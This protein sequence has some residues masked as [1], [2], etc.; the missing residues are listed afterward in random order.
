MDMNQNWSTGNISLC[1]EHHSNS[2]QKL[3]YSQVVKCVIYIVISVIILFALVGNLLIIIAI[4]H[5][6]QLHTPTNYFTLSLAVTDLLVG[7][8][9]MPPSMIRTVETC[10]YLGT[11]FC[12]IHSSLDV[13]LCTASDLNLAFISVERYYAV[14][15]PLL[16]HK[17][18]TPLTMMFM[19][20]VCWGYSFA[21]G[22]IV[23][24]L[25]IF[26]TEHFGDV[27]CEGGCA[28]VIGPVTALIVSLFSLYIPCIIMVSVYIKIYFVAQRQSRLV[29]ITLSQLNT[30]RGHPT[31]SKAERKATK[32]LAV[33]MGGFLSFWTPFCIYSTIVTFSGYSAP[34]QMLEIINWITYS[35]S[36]C[37]PMVYA[38][39]YS[40]F[41]KALKVM[42]SGK[43]FK[44][45][46]SRIKLCSE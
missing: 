5:F 36:A 3:I 17:I 10:W 11:L 42:L 21:V 9:V 6:K 32:T 12:K 16:Y 22:F 25:N 38:F 1:Y 24:E 37:N 34:P 39:F 33:V 26:G 46:S 45:R 20:V 19:I 35:N 4:I 7:G 31:V 27:I 2:C 8:V 13:I 15:H 23:I 44:K 28:I 14:C 18:I 43:I 29:H 41:R 40:W 30:S